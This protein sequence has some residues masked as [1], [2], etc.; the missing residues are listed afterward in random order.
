M[1]ESTLILT[2]VR[3][4][5]ITGDISSVQGPVTVR[6]DTYTQDRTDARSVLFSEQEAYW[7]LPLHETSIVK[8]VA[9]TK[10]SSSVSIPGIPLIVC[11]T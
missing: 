4:G 3:V 1:S 9:V 11:R 8:D 7:T 6:V 2:T 5:V 10:G